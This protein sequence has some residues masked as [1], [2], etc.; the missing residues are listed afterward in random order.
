MKVAVVFGTRP[1]AIKLAPVILALRKDERFQCRVCVTAQHREMLDQVLV[2]FGI[3]PDTDLD[4]MRKGQTLGELTSRALSALEGYFAEEKPDLVLCQGDTTTVFSAA[5]AAF[6]QGIAVGHVEAGLRTW[7]MQSPWPEEANRVLTTRLATLHFAPTETNR[8]NLLKEGISPKQIVLTGNTVIDALLHAVERA[9]LD[10]PVI[11][12]LNPALMRKG[13]SE[14][15]VLI[16][17]HR[18]ESFGGKLESICMAIADL[19]EKFPETHFVYPV[20]MNPQVRE[21]V[22]R[23]LGTQELGRKGNVHLIAPLHYF[24]FVALMERAS[25]L[26]TDSGGIQEEAPRLGKPVL[27]TR[28]TTERPEGML[29]GAAKLVGADRQKIV[30]EVSRLLTDAQ[31]YRQAANPQNP[32]GDGKAASRIVEAVAHHFGLTAAPAEYSVA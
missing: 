14:S 12:G 11:E 18:R 13:A 28:D 20:H 19:A 25:L 7:N 31:Y 15:I 8:Q 1:E 3:V 17:G 6:Y 5:L 4:L 22:Q 26:L 32:Y 27:V 9:R 24:Q 29:G 10:P 23:V 21:C 2:L 30:D 16:T